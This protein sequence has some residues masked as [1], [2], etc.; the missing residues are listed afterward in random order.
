MLVP[1][2]HGFPL[3]IEKSQSCVAQYSGMSD[4]WFQSTYP[5][6]YTFSFRHMRYFSK[7][8]PVICTYYI[9]KPKRP[10]FLFSLATYQS[11]ILL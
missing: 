10:Y 9:L 4:I 8:F 7:V 1:D 6:S 5:D 3:P 2:L 11:P